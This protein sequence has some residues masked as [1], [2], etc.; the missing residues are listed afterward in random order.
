M[1]NFKVI[2]CFFLDGIYKYGLLMDWSVFVGRAGAVI[3]SGTSVSKQDFKHSMVGN[4]TFGLK[5][6]DRCSH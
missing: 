4:L 3:L 5:S 1:E 2:R 6:S